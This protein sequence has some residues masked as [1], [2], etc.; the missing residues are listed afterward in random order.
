M[1][2]NSDSVSIVGE[3]HLLNTVLDELGLQEMNVQK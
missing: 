2:Q 1:I 3:V